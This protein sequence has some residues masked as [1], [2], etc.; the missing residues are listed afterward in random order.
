MREIVLDI[1][2]TGFLTSEGHRILEVTAVEI[3][4]HKLTGRE[5][6]VL[7]NPERDIPADS[8]RVH[9]ITNEKVADKPFFATIAKDLKDF[10]GDSSIIITCRTKEGDYVLD[11]AFLNMEMKKAGFAPFKDEQWVNVRRWS[12]AM[13]GEE[14]ASLDKVLDHYNIDRSERDRDGHSSTLDAQL[15]AA[16]YPKLLADYKKFSAKQKKPNTHHKLNPNP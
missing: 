15:L 6:H 9:G 1:E 7:V 5:L 12:E 11:V 4:G 13:F 14:N 3:K 8:T 2:S 16:V 10:I